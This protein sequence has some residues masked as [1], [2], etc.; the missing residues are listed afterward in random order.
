LARGPAPA[1]QTVGG[2]R[3]DTRT[4]QYHFL[5]TGV[6][7]ESINPKDPPGSITVGIVGAR[8]FGLSSEFGGEEICKLVMT[9][10]HQTL[11][12][13]FEVICPGITTLPLNLSSQAIFHACNAQQ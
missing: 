12:G 1:N 13:R 2:G 9:L 5:G 4:T 7:R 3:T 11:N 8:T 6:A 10:S